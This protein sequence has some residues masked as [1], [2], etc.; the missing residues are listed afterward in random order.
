MNSPPNE[1]GHALL[2]ASAAS[3]CLVLVE[4]LHLEHGNLARVDDPHGPGPAPVYSI[5][6]RSGAALG[7][8]LGLAVGLALLPVANQAVAVAL[9]LKLLALM[10]FFYLHFSGRLAY[11]FLNAGLYLAVIAEIG[12]ADP[13]AALPEARASLSGGSRGRGGRSIAKLDEWCGA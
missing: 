12:R 2:V 6:K 1:T 4:L 13:P 10:V 3:S 9:V 7:R 5:S 11:T 8:G